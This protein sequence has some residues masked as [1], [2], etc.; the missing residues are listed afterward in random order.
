MIAQM[1]TWWRCSSPDQNRAGIPIASFEWVSPIIRKSFLRRIVEGIVKI[2]GAISTSLDYHDSLGGCV[3]DD[4]KIVGPPFN[5]NISK[6]IITLLE[7][8]SSAGTM[9]LN[10]NHISRAQTICRQPDSG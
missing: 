5:W 9:K 10:K 4:I 1:C 2:L 6:L 7:R 3:A 8:M